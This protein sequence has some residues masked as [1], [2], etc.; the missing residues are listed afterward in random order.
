MQLNLIN[1]ASG[2]KEPV[3]A[4]D[5]KSLRFYCCGPTVYGPAH[6]GNFRTFLIQD[7]FRRTVEATGLKTK[8]V[9]NITD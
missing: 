7:V 6:I 5:N 8:H 3:F 4:E 9:R 1:T 2:K